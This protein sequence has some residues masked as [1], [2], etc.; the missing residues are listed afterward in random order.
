MFGC[1]TTFWIRSCNST[2]A[3]LLRSGKQLPSCA[4]RPPRKGDFSTSVTRS[5]WRAISSAAR[6]PAT[7]P[8][9]TSA[10]FSASRRIG[11]SGWSR[12]ALATP[13]RHQPKGFLGSGLSYRDRAPTSPAR[14]GRHDGTDNGFNP[15]RVTAPR[16][17]VHAA[18]GRR[19]RPPPG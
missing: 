4:M 11:S 13:G 16:K 14:A 5:P 7:P 6:R 18:S 19:R 17:S 1:A 15:A 2:C 9:M 3:L 12:R 10:C 8:P